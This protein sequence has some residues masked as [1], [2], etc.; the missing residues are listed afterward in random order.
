MAW[1][2]QFRFT[3]DQLAEAMP[4]CMDWRERGWGLLDLNGCMVQSIESWA[5][6]EAQIG[7][8]ITR[9]AHVLLSSPIPETPPANE[10]AEAWQTRRELEATIANELMVT[11]RLLIDQAAFWDG[12]GDR[13]IDLGVTY[14]ERGDAQE[15][16]LFIE[17]IT[18]RAVDLCLSDLRAAEQLRALGDQILALHLAERSAALAGWS[19]TLRGWR[20]TIASWQKTLKVMGSLGSAVQGVLKAPGAIGEAIGETA[21]KTL[22]G[23]LSS[24]WKWLALGFG[25]WLLVRQLDKSPAK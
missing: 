24:S 19:R 8:S 18:L 9:L 25:G 2:Y 12:I 4:G 17:G 21:G 22:S 13:L 10:L 15:S 16:A 23:F 11:G 6:I 3:K 20:D 5:A 14:R 7:V 1:D